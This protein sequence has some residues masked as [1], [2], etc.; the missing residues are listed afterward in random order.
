[1]HSQWLILTL[2]DRHLQG[3]IAEEFKARQ[4]AESSEDPQDLFQLAAEIV[5]Y[6][7]SHNAEADAC[8]LLME[9]SG[10]LQARG[11]ATER[12]P[13]QPTGLCRFMFLMRLC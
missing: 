3:E 12:R 10:V 1:V 9:V 7:L 6:C 4:S 8:D 5:P 11:T 13:H 2:C